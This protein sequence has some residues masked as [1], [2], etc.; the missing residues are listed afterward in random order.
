MTLTPAPVAVSV[1]S[2]D[3]RIDSEALEFAQRHHLVEYLDAAV[4][5][6]IRHFAPIEPVW[7]ELMID[8]EGDWDK[9]VLNVVAAEFVEGITECYNAYNNDIIAAILPDARYRISLT[10]DIRCPR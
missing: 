2:K 10:A 5:L 9:L 7:V 8:P 3:V 4:Q 1:P 6:A